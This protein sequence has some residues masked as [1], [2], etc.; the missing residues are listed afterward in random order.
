MPSNQQVYS[1][2]MDNNQDLNVKLLAERLEF[3]ESVLTQKLDTQTHDFEKKNELLT[4]D[5]DNKNRRLTKRILALESS[6]KKMKISMKQESSAETNPSEM[7]NGALSNYQKELSIVDE[8][9]EKMRTCIKTKEIQKEK[10]EENALE[11]IDVE[12]NKS[13][14]ISEEKKSY[15]EGLTIH[16]LNRIAAGRPFSR[17]IWSILVLSSFLAA[18]TIS[19]KHFDAFLSNESRTNIRILSENEVAF[20]AVTVC[21]SSF[22]EERK[23][24]DGRP[25]THPRPVIRENIFKDCFLTNLTVPNCGFNGSKLVNIAHYTSDFMTLVESLNGG[26]VID[27]T[28]HCFTYSG[29][30]ENVASNILNFGIMDNRS[31]GD[32]WSVMFI[33]SHTETFFE[34]TESLHWIL[35]GYYRAYLR[36]RIKTFLGLPYTDCIQGKGS[37]TQNKFTGNYTIGKCKKGCFLEKVFE[38]CG[39]I[40]TMYKKHLREPQLFEN[41]TFVNNT[42]GR[43]C[44]DNVKDDNKVTLECQNLCVLHPCYEEE[45][46]IN[47]GHHPATYKNYMEISLAFQSLT[48]EVI[49]EVPA[50]TWED[51][52]SNFGGCVGLMT[53]AS[54]LSLFELFI[55]F[56]LVILD[57]FGI[58]KKKI[59]SDK[60]N[61]ASSF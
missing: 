48:I 20:P 38:K 9:P 60:E 32:Y 45:I 8:N 57:Y 49:E 19:K 37:Y 23:N 15:A 36:K 22:F 44:M 42:F 5:I 33:N 56:G 50:Y 3:V 35:E 51:L 27:D 46:S 7:F 18:V 12:N 53:G 55:F 28:T 13:N 30:K 31:S 43:F 47:I 6:L 21:H 10:S 61:A 54:I 34:A 41:K 29:L 26:V 16:G 39:A 14:Q 1:P 2:K 58:F 40:P 59:V 25:P 4:Q 52:F 11:S 17:I 24:F